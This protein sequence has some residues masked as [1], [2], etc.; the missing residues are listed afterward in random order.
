MQKMEALLIKERPGMV[1][2]FGDVNSTLATA[3]AVAKINK[4]TRPRLVHVEAGL[5]SG[6]MRMPEEINRIAT[7]HLS[8]TLLTTC[9]EALEHLR[10][11]GIARNKIFFVGN[12][13]VDTLFTFAAHARTLGVAGTFGL[14]KNAFALLTLHRPE[15]VDNKKRFAALLEALGI[16]ADELPVLF[17]MHPRTVSQIKKLRLTAHFTKLSPSFRR[18]IATVPALGYF[19]F[20]SLMCDAR[21]VFTDSGGIQEETTALGIPCLTLRENTERP[22]TVTKGTNIVAGVRKNEVLTRS[23]RVIRGVMRKR[24]PIPFWDGKASVRIV[25]LLKKIYHER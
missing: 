19:E 7:D 9:P 10:R 17:P 14:K 20:L 15:N 21:C 8:D 4:K 1:V 3:L 23:R 22:I 18:G 16:I 11:E 12:V 25:S 2:V 5:R 6:D 24:A 13:M